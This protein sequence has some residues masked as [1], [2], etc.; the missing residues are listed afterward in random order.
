MFKMFQ[1]RTKIQK[2]LKKNKQKWNKIKKFFK[3]LYNSK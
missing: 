2:N 3:K 1:K